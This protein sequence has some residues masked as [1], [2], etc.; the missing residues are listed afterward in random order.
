MRINTNIG[1][2]NAYN[3]LENT[4][5]ALNDSLAKLSSGYRINK[6]ADDASGLVISQ[7]LMSQVSGLQQATRNAQDG[8]SVVQTAEG[9]LSSVQSMLQR[10]RDLV[11]QSANTGASDSTARQAAQQTALARPRAVERFKMRAKHF[12]DGIG[13]L[14]DVAGRSALFGDFFADGRNHCLDEIG[15]KCALTLVGVRQGFADEAEKAPGML[16]RMGLR[17][18]RIA[19]Q[20]RGV[21]QRDAK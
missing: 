13:E 6:A 19:I 21:G 1:A 10:I 17:L 7:N 4:N 9:A 18:G 15:A 16:A 11:I 12:A 8:I 14:L 5:G 20:R 2:L 3:N